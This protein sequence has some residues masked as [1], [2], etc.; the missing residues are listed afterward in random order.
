MFLVT[1]RNGGE[2]SA[3]QLPGQIQRGLT[4]LL[5]GGS[6]QMGRVVEWAVVVPSA[7]MP[8]S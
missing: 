4:H 6:A 7:A 5:K 2:V 8:V 3:S 1:L